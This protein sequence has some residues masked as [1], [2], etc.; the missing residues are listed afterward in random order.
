MRTV[1]IALLLFLA[2]LGG[3]VWNG[4]Y[5]HGVAADLSSELSALP[6]DPSPDLVDRVSALRDGWDA[7]VGIVGLSVGYTVLDRV[8]EQLALLVAACRSGDVLGYRQA[9]ALLSDA[10]DDLVRLERFSVENLL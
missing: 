9:I 6:A 1:W 2:M 7:R 4:F 3:I 5:V 8:G 10:L